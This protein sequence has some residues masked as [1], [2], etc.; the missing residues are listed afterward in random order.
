MEDV[1]KSYAS[2]RERKIDETKRINMKWSNESGRCREKNTKNKERTREAEKDVRIGKRENKKN[3]V[4]KGS[5][6]KSN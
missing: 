2:G 1:E 5:V 6:G 4:C 3:K